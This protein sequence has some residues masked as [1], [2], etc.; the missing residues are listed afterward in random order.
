MC[1]SCKQTFTIPFILPN[2]SAAHDPL[3]LSNARLPRTATC[4]FCSGHL[5]W[6]GC[7]EFWR[8]DACGLMDMECEAADPGAAAC[9][10]CAGAALVW[11]PWIEAWYC[12]CCD[13]YSF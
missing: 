8:C 11:N 9:D 13:V 7:D 12:C 3:N 10:G 2:T 1:N 4:T 6:W 5:T